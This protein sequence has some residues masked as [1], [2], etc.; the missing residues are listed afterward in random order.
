MALL[1]WSASSVVA[2]QRMVLILLPVQSIS[3]LTNDIASPTVDVTVD[4]GGKSR[5]VQRCA[6]TCLWSAR[7]RRTQGQVDDSCAVSLTSVSSEE[8]APSTLG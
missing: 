3:H 2:H 1:A 4:R 7:P 6:A 5:P 8:I